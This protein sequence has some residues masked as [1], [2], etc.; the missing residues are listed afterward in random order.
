MMKLICKTF[1]MQEI[2][3]MC[4]FGKM[5]GKTSV[6]QEIKIMCNFG[7]MDGVI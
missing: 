3:I 2:E 5:D 4:N 6:M 7:K 1:I